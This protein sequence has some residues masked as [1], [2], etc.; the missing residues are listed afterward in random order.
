MG[1][2]TTMGRRD[3]GVNV[4]EVRYEQLVN[5]QVKLGMFKEALKLSAYLRYSKKEMGFRDEL[6]SMAFKMAFPEDFEEVMAKLEMEEK[7]DKK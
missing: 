3:D 4:S 6:L 1:E 2:F 5:D 7:E